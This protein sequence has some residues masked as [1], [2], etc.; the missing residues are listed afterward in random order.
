MNNQH[1][2][3]L[4][5]QHYESFRII[6]DSS[7][8]SD[9]QSELDPVEQ[10]PLITNKVSNALFYCCLDIKACLRPVFKRCFY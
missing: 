6:S 8:D 2:T 4:N 5:S 3:T 9:S 1:V 10:I 7:L